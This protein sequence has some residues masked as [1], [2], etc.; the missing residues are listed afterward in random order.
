MRKIFFYIGIVFTISPV[1]A[2][3]DYDFLGKGARAAGM[4]CAFSAIADDATAMSWNPAGM[5]QIKK[6]EL[7]LANSLTTTENRFEDLNYKPRYMVDYLGFVYPLKH[8]MKDLVVGVSFQNKMNYKYAYSAIASMFNKND[9]KSKLTVNS[10]SLG[11]AYTLNRFIAA[12]FSYNA[13]F[14]MGNKEYM[15]DEYHH[16]QGNNTSVDADTTHIYKFKSNDSFSG[17]N[18]TAGI[19]L[20]FESLHFPLR[21]ALKYENRII[22]KKDLDETY[23]QDY[24]YKDYPDT[25]WIKKFRGVEKYYMP[26]TILH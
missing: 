3:Y 16:F 15:N 22:L 26:W 12:G 21:F 9:G 4:A 11:G 25:T 5:V 18:F 13:W 17:N 23:Q 7:A 24:I 2:Q 1:L 10:L 20:D 19:M 14:S 8:K 6:P